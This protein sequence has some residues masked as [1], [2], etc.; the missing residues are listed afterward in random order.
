MDWNNLKGGDPYALWDCVGDR[1][2][3]A[4][5]LTVLRGVYYKNEAQETAS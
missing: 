3:L 5:A 4:A 1:H 2:A